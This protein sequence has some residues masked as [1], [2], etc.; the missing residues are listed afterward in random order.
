MVLKTGRQPERRKIWTNKKKVREA[1][2][3]VNVR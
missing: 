2:V 3:V 1:V